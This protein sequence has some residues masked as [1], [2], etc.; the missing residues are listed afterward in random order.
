MRR[1]S[2]RALRALPAAAVGLAVL[3]GTVGALMPGTAV[4]ASER[5]RSGPAVGD[6]LL[7]DP[8]V[9]ARPAPDPRGVASVPGDRGAGAESP[10]TELVVAPRDS[11]NRWFDRAL[12]LTARNGETGD[13]VTRYSL[14]A[15]SSATSQYTT[16][17]SAC[18][19]LAAVQGDPGAL[20]PSGV[21]CTL[22][23]D[24]VT[25][26]AHGVWDRRLIRFERTYPNACVLRRETGQVF[27]FW[28]TRP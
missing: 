6:R 27:S 26:T 11:L 5:V 16:G 24:P 9:F 17:T 18:E 3:S 13:T 1:P 15:C 10:G 14:L 23:H 2:L 28:P 4:A 22:Q 20:Q 25:V 21:M 8:I 12:V 7:P 19:Q